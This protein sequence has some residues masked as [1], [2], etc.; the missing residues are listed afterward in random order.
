MHEYGR[1]LLFGRPARA[2]KHVRTGFLENHPMFLETCMA[3]FDRGARSGFREH[4]QSCKALFMH[5]A[6]RC[7]PS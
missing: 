1:D 6:R 5:R 3:R 4:P 2:K 7:S